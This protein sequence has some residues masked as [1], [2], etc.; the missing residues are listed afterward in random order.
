[1]R[2]T[3]QSCKLE[4]DKLTSAVYRCASFIVSSLVP[5]RSCQYSG[6]RFLPWLLTGNFR[7][8]RQVVLRTGG[9]EQI[10]F[11]LYTSPHDLTVYSLSLL[12]Y[13]NVFFV[14]STLSGSRS[15]FA[16]SRYTR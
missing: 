5:S 6:L 11:L 8:P 3:D 13:Q 14:N 2:L 10:A 4:R 16:E 1:M 7:P 9:R 15:G 12:V